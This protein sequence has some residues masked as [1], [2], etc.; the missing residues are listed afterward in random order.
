MY[1]KN[2]RESPGPRVGGIMSPEQEKVIRE[3][4]ASGPSHRSWGLRI[5]LAEIDR[6]RKQ[7]REA[8]VEGFMKA[9]EI[10]LDIK[11]NGGLVFIADKIEEEV[12]TL[13]KREEKDGLG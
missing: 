12:V 4:L 6:L 5:L 1:A 9:R 10:V 3:D 7:V 2:T 13:L 11:N 8:K